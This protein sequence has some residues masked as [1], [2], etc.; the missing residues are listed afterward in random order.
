MKVKS[1]L[2]VSCF[3]VSALAN[4]DIIGVSE[5]DQSKY[6]HLDSNGK[7]HCI[8]DPS[9]I[10]DPSQINDGICDCPDGSDEP[11]TNA[12]VEDS[13]SVFYCKNDGFKPRYILKNK[14]G[15]GLCDCCDCSDETFTDDINI[16]HKGLNCASV[17]KTF[18][19]I[20]KKE[21]ENYKKGLNE[22]NS[23]FNKYNILSP[24]EEFENNKVSIKEIDND[25]TILTKKLNNLKLQLDNEEANYKSTLQLSNPLLYEYNNNRNFNATLIKDL[26]SDFFKKLTKFDQSFLDIFEILEELSHSYT[27]SLN[28][29]VVNEN[30]YQFIKIQR[31]TEFNDL[32]AD[33]VNDVELGDQMVDYYAT[34]I[35]TMF[36]DLLSLKQD[37]KYLLGKSK[38]VPVL[39]NGKALYTE[40]VLDYILKFKAFMDDISENFNV[41]FQ[42]EAVLKANDEYKKYLDK[43]PADMFEKMLTLPDELSANMHSCE[44]FLNK[45]IPEL[46]EDIENDI[47]DMDDEDEIVEKPKSKGWGLN[48][49][50]RFNGLKNNDNSE[51]EKLL[52]LQKQIETHK[53]QTIQIENEIKSKND[54]LEHFKYL[55]TELS[56]KDEDKLKLNQLEELL[57]QLQFGDNTDVSQ[58]L[59]NYVYHISFSPE[60]GEIQQV[61][62][63]DNGNTVSIGRI[64]QMYFQSPQFRREQYISYLRANYGHDESMSDDNESFGED[65]FHHLINE[66]SSL[67][68]QEY[69]FGDLDTLNNGLTITYEGGERCW[70]GPERSAK[71][72]F[73]CSNEFK[74]KSVQEVTKCH[75]VF[76]VAAPLGCNKEL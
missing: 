1:C 49:K 27:K 7:W 20:E 44:T 68:D 45:K 73:T 4:S 57:K 5:E 16:F 56:N 8:S 24:T 62:N 74:V 41:N 29:R 17:K 32:I 21:L 60:N 14:V 34:E 31:K 66:T 54:K 51:K 15:D 75:Y 43:Y 23:L 70:N 40:Q 19:S 46:F 65:I 6:Q 42:D 67:G 18:S 71:I 61:E 9:I 28:D 13:I 33:P 69:L 58:L 47:I 55:E 10:L 50:K 35:P 59:D 26:L 48:L 63:K 12:C 11:G 2:L 52:I 39:V 36:T 72:I 64:T 76:D 22:L 3:L 30:I 25:V 37:Q 38:F 53:N